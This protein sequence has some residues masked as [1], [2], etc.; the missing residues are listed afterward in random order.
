MF[1]MCMVGLVDTRNYVLLVFKVIVVC[2]LRTGYRY[3]SLER[4]MED[5]GGTEDRGQR[6][7]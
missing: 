3:G 7:N 1:V 4:K 6:D 2:F 5:G